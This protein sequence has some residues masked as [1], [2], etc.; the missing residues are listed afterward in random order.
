MEATWFVDPPYADA[1]RAYKHGAQGI[2]FSALAD[3]CRSRN[4]QTVVC[5]NFGADWLPFREFRDIK[6]TAGAR[7]SGVSKEVIWTSEEEAA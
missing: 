6:G 1:G 4:G 5:E 3:W 2:D 7:R